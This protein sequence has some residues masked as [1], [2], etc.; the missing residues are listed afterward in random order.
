MH[1]FTIPGGGGKEVSLMQNRGSVLQ[2]NVSIVKK[3][4]CKKTK[5][6]S[7][8]EFYKTN[9]R[10]RKNTYILIKYIKESKHRKTAKN[11]NKARGR[12]KKLLEC[13]TT[14]STWLD[15]SRLRDGPSAIYDF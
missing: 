9:V 8:A 3:I 10:T 11:K 4:R 15:R 12:N 6:E 7:C 14:Y 13:N 2:K 5:R 1:Y